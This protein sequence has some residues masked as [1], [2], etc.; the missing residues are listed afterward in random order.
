MKRVIIHSNQLIAR[1]PKPVT[2]PTAIAEVE[3]TADAA[4][5]LADDDDAAGAD[6]V[7]VLLTCCPTTETATFDEFEHLS[8]PRVV[9]LLLKVISAH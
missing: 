9:A 7:L 3:P 1:A 5:V 6:D 2:T 8:L 4:E